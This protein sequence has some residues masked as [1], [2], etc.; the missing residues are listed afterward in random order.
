MSNIIAKAQTLVRRSP[1]VFFDD[2]V[3]ANTIV[4][5]ITMSKFRFTRR[6][7]GLVEGKSFSWYVGEREHSAA[8]EVR[9][10]EYRVTVM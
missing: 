5:A 10:N 3:D 7:T 9:L 8:I 6:D 1:R 4:D 2:I